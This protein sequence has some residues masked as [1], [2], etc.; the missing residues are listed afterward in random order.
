MTQMEAFARL[1]VN[2]SFSKTADEMYL[3][4][5]AISLAISRMEDELSVT[6]FTR[7][8][9]K[10]EMTDEGKKLLRYV[11]PIIKNYYAINEVFANHH[12]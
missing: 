8:F 6:L 7:S 9:K 4:Q 1:A 11:H 10:A 12:I 3:T 2:G 5:P